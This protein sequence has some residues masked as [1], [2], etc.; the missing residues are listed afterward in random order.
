MVIETWF[1]L[2]VG[3]LN[4]LRSGRSF[5]RRQCYCFIVVVV[6]GAAAAAAV[7]IMYGC[8][9]EHHRRS[10]DCNNDIVTGHHAPPRFSF[11]RLLRL[12]VWDNISIH[13]WDFQ[14][15]VKL[16]FLLALSKNLNL[17]LRTSI[18]KLVYYK[19]I[20]GKEAQSFYKSPVIT[21]M[22]IKFF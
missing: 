22:K 18:I 12:L 3:Q 13:L 10:T 20:D 2:H 4:I 16:Y 6:V 14:V 17:N 15:N 11:H 1:R 5:Y 21:K 19:T 8:A 7:D 9:A